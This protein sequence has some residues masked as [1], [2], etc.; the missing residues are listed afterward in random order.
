MAAVFALHLERSTVRRHVQDKH[1]QLGAPGTWATVKS[2]KYLSLK[3]RDKWQ[4]RGC[5][6]CAPIG[7]VDIRLLASLAYTEP[8]QK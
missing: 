4:R 6:G 5:S 8:Q 2:L 7:L 3:L 1:L